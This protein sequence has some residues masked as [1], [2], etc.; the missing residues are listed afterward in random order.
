MLPRRAG[1]RTLSQGSES[2]LCR[3]FPAELRE[4]GCAPSELLT[5]TIEE[6]REGA[7]DARTLREAG[8]TAADVREA[9]YTPAQMREAGYAAMEMRSLGA[10]LEELRIAGWSTLALRVAGFSELPQRTEIL[11]L[12]L[13]LNSAPREQ[14]C[15]YLGTLT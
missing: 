5:L 15:E 14:R 6:I 1:G 10:S 3:L 9:G 4:A 12:T 7:Y 2:A 8:R 11:I 13:S